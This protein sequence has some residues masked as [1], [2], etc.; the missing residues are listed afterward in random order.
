M[1]HI[2][3]FKQYISTNINIKQDKIEN[4]SRMTEYN[5]YKDDKQKQNKII[6]TEIVVM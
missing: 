6:K 4:L 5:D 1:N 3:E 2:H